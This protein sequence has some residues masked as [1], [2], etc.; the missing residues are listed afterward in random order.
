MPD[1]EAMLALGF[2]G[3]QL[4][5]RWGNKKLQELR[6]NDVGGFSQDA[7]DDHEAEE[8]EAGLLNLVRRLSYERPAR[9]HKRARLSPG[10]PVP[11]KLVRCLHSRT[12]AP[13]DVPFFRP[14][15]NSVDP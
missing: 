10:T 13:N 9:L 12:A 14:I 7:R 8:E 3:L 1:L 6:A 15:H 11:A 4:W 2:S 5:R